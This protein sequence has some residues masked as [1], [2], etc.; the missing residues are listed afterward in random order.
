MPRV[1]P[2]IEQK[3]TEQHH[4]LPPSLIE[5]ISGFTAGIVSTV[6]VH[7]FDVVKT[8]LQGTLLV[9]CKTNIANLANISVVD[10]AHK[11]HVGGSISIVKNIWKNEG[12]SHGFY[13]GIAPN[14]I[15]NSISWG[16]YFMWYG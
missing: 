10:Q 6:A 15:G 1:Y 14:M 8:R 12:I 4:A 7:P 5:V 16:L 3:P 2:P 13:R 9:L 11:P